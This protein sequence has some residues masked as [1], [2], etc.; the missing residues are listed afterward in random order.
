MT[1]QLTEHLVRKL[2]AD[3]LTNNIIFL[4]AS[5]EGFETWNSCSEEQLDRSQ[6]PTKDTQSSRYYGVYL[7]GEQFKAKVGVV[8][9]F[10]D[11]R[12]M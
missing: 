4:I 9:D 2:L 5:F 1:G 10:V 8:L 12:R 3:R 6:I 11:K 7:L